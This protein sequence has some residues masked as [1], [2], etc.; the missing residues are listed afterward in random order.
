MCERF[1]LT[2]DIVQL[3]QT[4]GITKMMTPYRRR[5]NI[6][7]LQQVPIVIGKLHERELV[8][9]RW[10][11]FPYW[12]KDSVNADYDAV[13]GKK[14]FER[15][16]KRQRCIVPCSGFY[17][18][19]TEGKL[20]SSLRVVLRD[21]PV[22]GMAGLY[23]TRVDPRG[24]EHRTFTIVTTMSNRIVSEY[25]E[26]MP[27]ILEA[28]DMDL[29]LDANATD[30]SC[31]NSRIYPYAASGMDSYPVNP[32]LQLE[33][34]DTPDCIVQYDPGTLTVKR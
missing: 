3:Q 33:E 27:V 34:L 11:F 29:W 7:P 5:Y 23:E 6:S 10:G 12:A 4:F 19:R 17:M 22:F 28:E 9:S 8:D 20:S 13:S 1:S 21:K 18:T 32:R 24:L 26:R 25:T 31:W 15:I 16:L 30:T 2:A 14:I